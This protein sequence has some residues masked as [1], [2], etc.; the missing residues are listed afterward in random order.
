M[1]AFKEQ[2][3]SDIQNVFLNTDEFADMHVI[4]DKSM[5]VTIDE[6]ELEEFDN[7]KNY[8]FDGLYKAKMVIY[9]DAEVLGY[10]PAIQSSMKVNGKK[11]FVMNVSN[12]GGM[13]KIL[14]GVNRA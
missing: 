14:L 4:N 8:D 2:L 3:K 5:P 9:L 12:S 10:V 11:Y 7:L 1:S 6:D 13:L